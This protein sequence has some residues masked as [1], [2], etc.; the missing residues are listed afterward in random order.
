MS[1]MFYQ[2]QQ[3][4]VLEVGINLA[5]ILDERGDEFHVPVSSL[6][7]VPAKKMSGFDRNLGVVVGYLRDAGSLGL[8]ADEG[9]KRL[10]EE[11]HDGKPKVNSV[12]PVFTFLKKAGAVEVVGS[13]STRNG[14]SAKAYQLVSDYE[15]IL[16]AQ[17]R[18]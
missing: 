7:E 5:R 11:D 14:K 1:T 16:N 12:A 3:V 13:R 2:Q 8:I 17:Q 15:Q 10:E 4:E 6:T 9:V 18:I